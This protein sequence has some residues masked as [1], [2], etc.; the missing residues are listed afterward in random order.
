MCV[1]TNEL[2]ESFYHSAAALVPR[3]SVDAVR[4][5]DFVSS[6]GRSRVDPNGIKDFRKKV[7]NWLKKG[8]IDQ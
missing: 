4:I 5:G 8:E 2:K 7:V 1:I 3:T 6:D